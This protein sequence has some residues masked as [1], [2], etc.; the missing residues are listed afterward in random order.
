V[1]LETSK[2]FRAVP[3]DFNHL[4][5]AE[6]SF[7]AKNATISRWS[8][9]TSVERTA[10]TDHMRHGFLLKLADQA[11]PDHKLSDA[12]RMDAAKRLR[13][14]HMARITAKSLATRRRKFAARKAARE[15]DAGGAA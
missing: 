13:A 7:Y 2:G 14:A 5:A 9:L 8:R 6:R 10:A 3:R 4:S 11:D 15:A 12:E 1:P